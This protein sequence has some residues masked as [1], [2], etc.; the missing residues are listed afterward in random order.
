MLHC[1]KVNIYISSDLKSLLSL[2]ITFIGWK[3]GG[4]YNTAEYYVI[5]ILLV[6]SICKNSR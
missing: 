6:M 2:F 3:P 5:I 4:K 1:Y